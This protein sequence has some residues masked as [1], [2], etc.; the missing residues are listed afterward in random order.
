MVAISFNSYV[1][2][3]RVSEMK[4]IIS[5]VVLFG[6]LSNA[7]CSL[8]EEADKNQVNYVPIHKLSTYVYVTRSDKT[9]QSYCCKNFESLSNLTTLSLNTMFLHKL[10]HVC[11]QS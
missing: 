1:P 4:F 10:H 11:R 9:M 8:M 6:I 5:I 2:T 3:G 7:T